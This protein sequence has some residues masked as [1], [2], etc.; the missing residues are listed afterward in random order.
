M[1][2]SKFYQF[3]VNLTGIEFKV[4]L[5]LSFN[6]NSVVIVSKSRL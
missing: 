1:V 6:S 3:K 2:N 5:I 4:V